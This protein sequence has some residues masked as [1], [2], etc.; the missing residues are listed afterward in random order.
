M[1]DWRANTHPPRGIAR[2]RTP[3]PGRKS[4]IHQSPAPTGGQRRIDPF[5]A[6]VPAETR[7]GVVLLHHDRLEGPARFFGAFAVQFHGMGEAFPTTNLLQWLPP[8]RTPTDTAEKLCIFCHDG[9]DFP[10]PR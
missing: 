1:P 5:S 6:L 7:I 2:A 3:Y 9:R 4:G 10:Q 8:C